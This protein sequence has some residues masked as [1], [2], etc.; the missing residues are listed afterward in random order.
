MNK[1][2][3]IA[4]NAETLGQE[5]SGHRSTTLINFVFNYSAFNYSAHVLIHEFLEKPWIF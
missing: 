1:G 2:E 3:L 5:G 4:K